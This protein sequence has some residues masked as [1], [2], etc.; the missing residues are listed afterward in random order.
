MA[1]GHIYPAERA[2]GALSGAFQAGNL[3][4]PRDV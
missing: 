3:A 4:V 2:E 1:R